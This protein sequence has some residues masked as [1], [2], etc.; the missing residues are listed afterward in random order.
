[1][2]FKKI[3]NNKMI[4]YINIVQCIMYEITANQMKA[5]LLSDIS[6]FLLVIIL[7]YKYLNAYLLFFFLRI[8]I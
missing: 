3:V 6:I 2:D 1:M 8:F 4:V 5:F 7:F